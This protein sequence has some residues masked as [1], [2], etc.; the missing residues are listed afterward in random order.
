MTMNDLKRK[1]AVVGTG[2]VG[3][4]NAKQSPIVDQEIS[5]YLQHKN[6][7]TIVLTK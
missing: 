5:E 7:Q 2:Y 6:E 4:S 3:L 1:I